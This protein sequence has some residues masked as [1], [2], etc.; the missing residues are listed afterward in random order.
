MQE[1]AALLLHYN[2]QMAISQVWD[3][4]NVKLT[5]RRN[6]TAPLVEQ[7]YESEQKALFFLW[8]VIDSFGNTLLTGNTH[9]FHL[10]HHHF[11][12]FR[13]V[14]PIFIP[15]IWSSRIHNF[16]WLLAN[17]KLMT[18]DN[19]ERKKRWA[20]ASLFLVCFAMN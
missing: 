15:T 3:G 12:S 2:G 19:L 11:I 20:R 18:R 10:Q 14:V 13:G 4:G 16:L 6:F 17:N 9:Q 7:W 5:L 8:T 1:E